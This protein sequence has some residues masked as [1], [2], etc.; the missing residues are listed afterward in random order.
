MEVHIDKRYPLDVDPARAWQALRDVRGVAACMP[1]AA[2]TEQIDATHYKGSVKVKIGPANTSFAGDIE[3]LALDEAA[4]TLRMLGKGAD[5]SGS[6]A[7]MDLTA[8]VEVGESAT[9]STLVGLANVT[10]SG[11]FAQFGSR[12]IVP[13]SDALLEQFVEHFRTYAASMPV[14]ESAE[15]APAPATSEGADV[16]IAPQPSPASLPP[17]PPAPPREVRELNALALAWAVVKGWFAGLFGK[18]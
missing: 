5:R 18:R 12:L 3:V 7:S 9:S 17:P 2:I 10:V 6:S 13:V 4:H 14:S 8:R 15:V 16:A 11:K 1:G